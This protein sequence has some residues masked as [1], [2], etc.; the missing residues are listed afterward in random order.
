MLEQPPRTANFTRDGLKITKTPPLLLE[1]LQSFFEITKFNYS[2]EVNLTAIQIRNQFNLNLL[3][4]MSSFFRALANFPHLRF[5]IS[6]DIVN[7][8][9]VFRSTAER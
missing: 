1:A 9:K 3:P 5:C 7:G 2:R 6:S 8:V 4:F